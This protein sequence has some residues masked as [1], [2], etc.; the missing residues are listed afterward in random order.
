MGENIADHE[1][2]SPVAQSPQ[3]GGLVRIRMYSK[4]LV[5]SSSGCFLAHVSVL[6]HVFVCVPVGRA[7]R[8]VSDTYLTDTFLRHCWE[9]A[10]RYLAA[11]Q[12][13]R[14]SWYYTMVRNIYIIKRPMIGAK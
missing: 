1:M 6:D 11:A 8:P 2:S 13:S 9:F 10:E 12:P 5:W 4:L 14:S 3:L 7:R